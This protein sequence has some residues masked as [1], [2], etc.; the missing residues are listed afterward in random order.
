MTLSNKKSWIGLGVILVALFV[1]PQVN[2]SSSCIIRMSYLQLSGWEA[3]SV[4]EHLMIIC[5]GG[6]KIARD[7]V[8]IVMKSAIHLLPGITLKSKLRK[9]EKRI[10]KYT[11]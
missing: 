8:L 5:S 9:E 3:I 4:K 7:R 11:I 2:T 6:R 1:P 10:I